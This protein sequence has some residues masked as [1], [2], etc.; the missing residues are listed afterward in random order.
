MHSPHTPTISV[1]IP[2]LNSAQVLESALESCLQQRFEIWEC[3]IKDGGSTDGTQQIAQEY[4]EDDPR[5][6][7][8]E[9]EDRSVY[10]GM[11]QAID[12]ARGDYL[13]F[14]GADDR[15]VNSFHQIVPLLQRPD[16]VYYGSVF[17]ENGRRFYR[18]EF[19]TELLLSFN[20]CHQSIFYPRT[21]FKH[22]RY[23]DNFALWAD[24]ELN[25]EL[26]LDDRFQFQ[27]FPILTALY[28]QGGISSEVDG[29]D[30]G[31]EKHLQESIVPRIDQ[32][33]S[34]QRNMRN[35]LRRRICRFLLRKMGYAIPITGL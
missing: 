19:D 18:G 5:F 10:D 35:A 20:L 31:W 11:N 30:T 26:W 15:L 6:R 9:K 23:S 27:Y 21:A 28:E 7:L 22:F 34:A 1:I 32:S 24:Y 17:M 33:K 25:W 2:T 16:T 3:I 14:L 29:S 4:V 13:I 8:I 12:E